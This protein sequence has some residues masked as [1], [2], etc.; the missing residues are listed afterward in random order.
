MFDFDPVYP[1][2]VRSQHLWREHP[3]ALV[4]GTG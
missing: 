2:N 4:D 1:L 3:T